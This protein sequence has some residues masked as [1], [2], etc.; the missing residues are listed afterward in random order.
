MPGLTTNVIVGTRPG[1]ANE[2]A[3]Y[4]IGVREDNRIV[5]N[6]CQS[7]LQSFEGWVEVPGEGRTNAAPSFAYYYLNFYP[8]VK[9]IN[10]FVYIQTSHAKWYPVPGRTTDVAPESAHGGRT[11]FDE[12]RLYLFIKDAQDNRIYMNA[13]HRTIN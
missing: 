11:G 8:L 6:H 1:D 12:E 7:N 10:N 13:G 2:S 3:I 9:G 5:Q 4:L